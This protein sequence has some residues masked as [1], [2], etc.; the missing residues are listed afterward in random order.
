MKVVAGI[1]P[2]R[3]PA[4]VGDYARRVERLGYDA[5]HVPEMVQDPFVVAALAL[6]ATSRIRVRTAVALAFVRSAMATAMSAWTLA[7][8]SSGRFDLG[9]GSQVRAN[10]EDRYGSA[11][12]RPVD[13]MADHIAA[14]R[15]CF[16]GF[17]GA[18]V[19]HLGEYVTL[20]RLQPD[21]RP[22][23]LP[24][25]SV[26]AIWLGGV[27]PRMVALAGR[28]A[29]GLLTHPTASHPAD[30]EHRLVPNLRRGAEEARRPVPP[31][32]VAPFVATGSDDAVVRAMVDRHRRRLA[33]LFSTRAYAPALD[34][35]GHATLGA[36]LRALARSGRWDDMQHLLPD[37]VLRHVVVAAV[38]AD[39]ADVLLERY[40]DLVDA[41]M[42]RPPEDP[43]HDGSWAAVVAA[44]QASPAGPAG[45]GA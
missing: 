16:A 44:L 25:A 37:D 6:H 3:P 13:R 17:G 4:A 9:L 36:E 7:Q 22:D 40:G 2:R 28:S 27:G 5:L 11:F 8:L 31:V 18:D 10:I 29:D 23:P 1:D 33:F 14:I 19:E 34:A 26:P 38:Y 35:I 20:R 21:F 39:L 30:L 41:V 15:A 24:E 32:V 42:V 43:D 45:A 12:S